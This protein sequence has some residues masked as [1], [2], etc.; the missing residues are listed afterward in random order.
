MMASVDWVCA[1][2]ARV[3]AGRLRVKVLRIKIRALQSTRVLVF[4]WLGEL[5]L[6]RVIATS[7]TVAPISDHECNVG[8]LVQ[9]HVSLSPRA[10]QRFTVRNNGHQLFKTGL[11]GRIIVFSLS[12]YPF[13]NFPRKGKVISTHFREEVFDDLVQSSRSRI[14]DTKEITSC[15]QLK[16]KIKDYDRTERMPTVA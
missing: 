8:H 11:L 4:T 2:P 15:K 13:M 3:Q 16:M 9:L 7:L 14:K 6:S 12:H 5:S 1:L 10:L